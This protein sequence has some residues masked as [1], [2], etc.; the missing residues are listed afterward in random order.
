MPLC[1]P[2]WLDLLRNILN[3][4]IFTKLWCLYP[5][6]PR[7]KMQVFNR[8]LFFIALHSG[9]QAIIYHF[10]II[11]KIINN[12]FCRGTTWRSCDKKE[13]WNKIRV[14]INCNNIWQ[15]FT[16]KYKDKWIK[17]HLQIKTFAI[18]T[19]DVKTITRKI[20]PRDRKTE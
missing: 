2:T 12:H 15:C 16:Q 19:I 10:R 13:W 4:G 20:A 11:S 6:E 9:W 1:W 17:I 3:C 7:E 18:Y 8:S 5:S 14:K